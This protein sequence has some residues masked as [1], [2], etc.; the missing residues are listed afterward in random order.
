MDNRLIARRAIVLGIESSIKSIES[1]ISGRD[2]LFL[3]NLC[4]LSEPKFPNWDCLVKLYTII[5]NRVSFRSLCSELDVKADFYNDIFL[6][7]RGECHF[8]EIEV[9]LDVLC[10]YW[11][12]GAYNIIRSENGMVK[13]KVCDL[14]GI[15]LCDACFAE[16]W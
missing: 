10:A 4:N 5:V 13:L 3:K 9:P 12:H 14:K 16:D 6:V 15:G 8:Q 2:F 1:S 7:K 11:G